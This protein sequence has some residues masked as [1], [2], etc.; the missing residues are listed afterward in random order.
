MDLLSDVLDVIRLTGGVFFTARLCSAW[1][2]RSPP[3]V[4]LARSLGLRPGCVSVF[5]ILAAGHCFVELEGLDPVEVEPGTI[6][7]LPHADEHVLASRPDLEPTPL[8]RLLTHISAERVLS[9]KY[10]RGEE[11][12]RLVCGYLACDQRFNPLVGAL[13]TLLIASPR[14]AM[15]VAGPGEQARH[16]APTAEAGWMDTVLQH[17]IQEAES[18]R[19]GSPAMLA[20]LSELMFMGILRQYVDLLPDGA[21]GWLAAVRHPEVG[22]AL[23]LLHREP[24]RSWTVEELARAVHLSRSALGQRFTETVGEPPMHYLA[25]WRMQLAKQ[26]LAQPE[27]S[28]AQVAARVGYHSEV[29]FHRAFRRHVGRTPA[30]WRGDSFRGA[31]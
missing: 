15:V 10:G 9:V 5:H 25:G 8:T 23:R 16:L 20:R 17:T 21:T 4:E 7:L 14:H 27:L 24:Q 22:R 6:I 1:S 26:L 30:T 3:G 29:A 12:G 28:V 13:P 31:G 19:P 2:F 18:D 11:T